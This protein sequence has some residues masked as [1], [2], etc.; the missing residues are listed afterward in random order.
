MSTFETHLIRGTNEH[1]VLSPDGTVLAYSHVVQ[2]PL[3]LFTVVKGTKW[4]GVYN[5]AKAISMLK[6]MA[7]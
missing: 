3:N 7:V 5:E 2:I 4:I 1:R 6:G